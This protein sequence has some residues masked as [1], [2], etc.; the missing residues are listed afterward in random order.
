MGLAVCQTIVQSHDG[1][2]AFE[3]G[4]TGTCFSVSFP[5]SQRPMSGIIETR[6]R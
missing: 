5:R 4:P 3:S 2:I 6:E 1:E